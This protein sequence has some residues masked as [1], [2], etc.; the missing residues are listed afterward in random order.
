MTSAR[1]KLTLYALLAAAGLL[2]LW[3]SRLSLFTLVLSFIA[4]VALPRERDAGRRVLF[5]LV[6]CAGLASFVGFGR[7]SIREAVPGIVEGG[8]RATSDAAVSRLREILFAEDVM[9]R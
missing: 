5:Y 6:L 8:T 3:L 7:F 2:S 1:L 4:F 9:R